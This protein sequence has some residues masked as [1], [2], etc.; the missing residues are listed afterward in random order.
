MITLPERK[1]QTTLIMQQSMLLPFYARVKYSQLY[2]KL[3]YDQQAI[4]LFP[5]L[6]D[7]LKIT[8]AELELLEDFVDEFN[9]LFYLISAKKFENYI[10]RTIH[11]NPRITIVNLGCGLDT[12]YSR[13][14]N[15]KISWYDLDLPAVIAFRQRFFGKQQKAPCI[16][17][18]IFDYSWMEQINYQTKNGILFVA[19]GLLHYFQVEQV[20]ELL[21]T[22]RKQFP[23]GQI[24]FNVASRF[25]NKII[26]KRLQKKNL[27]EMS[28]RLS[29][30]NPSKE[31]KQWSKHFSIVD[32][33]AI[34]FGIKR[35]KRWSL[36]TRITMNLVD[37]FAALKIIHL[38]F[39]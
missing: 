20:K 6:N 30:N 5:K 9:G 33:E 38:K 16:A 15:E 12:S 7:E 28:V 3:F 1:Q 10:I 34:F 29:V 8:K 31:I 13:V 32:W 39:I 17:K 22:I 11:N 18:D 24:L 35:D 19:S 23:H 36:R 21:L 4:D 37:G 2:P 14:D 26:N 27:E 25:A